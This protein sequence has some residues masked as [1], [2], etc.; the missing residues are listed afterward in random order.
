MK[1]MS[2]CSTHGSGDF[3]IGAFRWAQVEVCVSMVN[4][5]NGWKGERGSSEQ[6]RQ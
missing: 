6:E 2:A 3:A 4:S 1:G 5:M